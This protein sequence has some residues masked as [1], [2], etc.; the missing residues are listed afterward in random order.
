MTINFFK[1]R[2]FRS[3]NNETIGDLTKGSFQKMN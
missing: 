3:N 2:I 1:A